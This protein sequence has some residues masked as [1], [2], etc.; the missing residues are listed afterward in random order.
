M[1]SFDKRMT[2]V[3][4]M[5]GVALLAFALLIQA[6]PTS[7]V[8]AAD[9][10]P[11]LI[12]PIDQANFLPGQK[13]DVQIEVWADT[14]PSDFAVKI[15]G[16][17]ASDMLGSKPKSE[18]WK[19]DAAKGNATTY[20]YRKGLSGMITSQATTWRG[21]S[22]S[23][24]GDYKIDVTA[25]GATT[26]ATWTVRKI[27][28][29]KAKNVIFF[30]G[31]GMATGIRTATRLVSRGLNKGGKYNDHLNM[32]KMSALGLVSTNGYD[33]IITDSANSMSAYM[34]GQKGVVNALG[35]YPNTSDSNDDDPHVATF[36]E[37]AKGRG[38]TV[39]TC[40]TSAVTDATPAATW[41]HTRRRGD[42]DKLIEQALAMNYDVIL[43]GGSV[44]FQPKSTAG[45]ERKDEKDMFKAFE[46]AGYKVVTSATDLKA[47]DASKTDKLVGVFSASHLNVW[48]D[49]HLFPEVT[50]KNG[51]D[52]PDLLDECKAAIDILSKNDKG[53]FLMV[54][55][56]DIDKQEHTMSWQR[57]VADTIEFDN[58]VGYAQDWAAKHGNNTLIA[59]TADHAH[60]FD[61]YG[62]VDMAAYDKLAA[63]MNAAPAAATMSATTLATT[64]AVPTVA[65]S[66]TAAAAVTAA[67]TKAAT[68]PA[69]VFPAADKRLNAIGVY[70]AAGMVDYAPDANH[71]PQTWDVKYPLAVAWGDH[72][73][74]TD[75]F[76]LDKAPNAPAIAQ[77]GNVSPNTQRDPDGVYFSGNLPLNANQAVHT[78]Q[79][80]QINAMGPGAECFNGYHDN[81]D[82]FFCLAGSL[83]LD[84]RQSMSA[85]AAPTAP[86]TKS[87]AIPAALIGMVL[88]G[89]A[90]KRRTL[91]G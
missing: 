15:N 31:D 21:V 45:S 24:A 41:G 17:D 43:G 66:P 60:A 33:S 47:I 69:R 73:P 91:I 89:G 57:A 18:N 67:A 40:V 81:T 30:L 39:G 70:E 76:R 52:Q 72:P 12:L 50:K 16:K 62:T 35:V 88:A 86:A 8:R 42:E 51:A 87:A 7:A 6:L 58:V 26:S 83:S 11:V 27:G 79:D 20:T 56:S 46:A 74:Y 55:G 44:F 90:L 84:P 80:V 71:F 2:R 10:T 54:E 77:D 3:V 25:N 49:R 34:T 28:E 36:A 5:A 63:A 23:D 65:G 82:V 29:G 19:F 85:P 38:M 14:L 13:F 32:E 78:L 9:A 64:A 75:D 48:I 22:L 37:L 68:A 53:F 4:S 61:V 1:K 59:V